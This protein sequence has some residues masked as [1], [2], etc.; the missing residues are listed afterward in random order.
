M[1][2]RLP[3]TLEISDA[4]DTST[5]C[6]FCGMPEAHPDD[7]DGW[8]DHLGNVH[9]YKVVVDGRRLPNARRSHVIK[10]ALVGWFSQAKFQ[11]ND[12]VTVNDKA[13]SDYRGRRGTVV[14]FL[15]GR[16]TYAASF[17]EEP[18]LGWLHS[19]WLDS[20]V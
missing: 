11:P 1:A 18:V 4:A 8:A 17:D 7:L 19:E 12:P 10:L 9:G 5:P 14:G 16:S 6:E 20:S 3:E 2:I 13:P 15:I